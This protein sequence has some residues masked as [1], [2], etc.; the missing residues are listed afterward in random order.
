MTKNMDGTEQLIWAAS[1]GAEWR[2]AYWMLGAAGD[3]DPQDE[4]SRR[5]LD[6]AV[7]V[8]DAAVRALRASDPCGK[9]HPDRV[10][11][12]PLPKGHGD[13]CFLPADRE[14]R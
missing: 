4:A 2:E 14:R 3:W 11:E 9:L 1:F 5:A 7:Q 6:R 12:C 10:T 8:A 13:P